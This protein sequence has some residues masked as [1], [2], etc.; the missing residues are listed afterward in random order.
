MT[1]TRPITVLIADDHEIVRRGV[2]TYFASQP[3]LKVVAECRSGH[4]AVEAAS[5]VRPDVAIVDLHM[6]RMDGLEATR[7]IRA[8][9]PTTRVVVL[10]SF[11]GD[12]EIFPALRAG[13]LSYL[14][15]DVGADELADAVRRAAQGEPSLSPRIAR[16]LMMDVVGGADGPA[17]EPLTARETEVLRWVGLGLSNRRIAARLGIAEATVKG[18]LG[19]V[20]AK[21][22]VDDRTQA[23][24]HAWRI[25][26][27]SREDDAD[28]QPEA[29]QDAAA[30]EPEDAAS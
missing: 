22:G 5:A 12:D 14:L 26:L 2:S 6:P 13:A 30:L 7:R 18:H 16:R 15:K 19:H 9:S 8:A 24:V 27:V 1:S 28:A 23:A 25:G 4:E 17:P 21:L 11:S 20:M 10:S 29:R 3:D